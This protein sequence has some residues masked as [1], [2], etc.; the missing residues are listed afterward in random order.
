MSA[1]QQPAKT[2]PR[3]LGRV[4]KSQLQ[5]AYIHLQPAAMTE[6]CFA[7]RMSNSDFRKLV[8][9]EQQVTRRYVT[10]RHRYCRCGRE[11][12]WLGRW[13]EMRGTSPPT[14]AVQLK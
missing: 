14:V 12:R 7:A 3:N 2:H 1:M 5:M 6:S 4:H 10:G 13:T 11:N 9:D 8:R